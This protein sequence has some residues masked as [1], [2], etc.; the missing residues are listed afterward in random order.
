M[1]ASW[2]RKLAH[3]GV[4][5]IDGGTGSELVRRGFRLSEL[6]WSGLASASHQH[7]LTEVHADF[8]RAGG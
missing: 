5:L 2:Q 6:A 8:I 1:S 3:G 4:V 7:L